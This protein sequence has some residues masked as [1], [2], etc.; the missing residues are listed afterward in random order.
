MRETLLRCEVF[1][2]CKAVFSNGEHVSIA[3]SLP[4][5]HTSVFIRAVPV[6]SFGREAVS[7]PH[8]DSGLPCFDDGP[9]LIRKVGSAIDNPSNP[10]GE[11]RRRQ[12]SG[13]YC[14][15]GSPAADNIQARGL[16]CF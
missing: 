13:S 1:E 10:L 9:D 5:P 15:V 7:L 14:A 3:S 16:V 4:L 2:C 12:E 11:G 8:K 6:P